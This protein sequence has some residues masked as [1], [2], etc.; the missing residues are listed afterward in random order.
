MYS[1]AENIGRGH[2]FLVNPD[3]G[4][5][6][7]QD[8]GHYP[9]PDI[10]SIAQIALLAQVSG[11]PIWAVNAFALGTFFTVAVAFY[12]AARIEGVSR[13][14]AVVLAVAFSV[15]PWHFVRATGHV[16]LA[17][18]MSVP[19]AIALISVVARR[20]L[21]R[22][23]S[24]GL[25]LLAGGAAVVV[26]A[27]GIYYALLTT[28]LL[29]A[30]LVLA[31]ARSG[32]PGWRTLGVAVLVPLSTAA[33]IAV[34]KA[35][36]STPSVGETVV[37]SPA[38]SYLYG[39]NIA[40]LFSPGRS[41]ATGEWLDGF[42]S[43]SFPNNGT[44]EGES[45]L[46]AAGVLAVLITCWMAAYRWTSGERLV[47]GSATARSSFWPGLFVLVVAFFA[48]GGFGALFLVLGECGHSRVGAF[49]HLRGGNRLPRLRVG[50]HGVGRQ[51]PSP[52]QDHRRGARR[53][54]GIAR[55][56]GRLLRPLRPEPG[57]VPRS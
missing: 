27:N 19:L 43:L 22:G 1:L 3:L 24:V 40:T 23:P 11:S 38:E 26:G 34:S 32:M 41:T 48:A 50:A 15:L 2:W 13:P 17:S 16:F 18:Y 53:G 49:L 44:F 9:I 42:L 54:H 20:R 57:A 7:F 29:V 55:R 35:S 21:D 4:Y 37:R 5:P 30:V 8:L 12:A 28:M 31:A 25:V 51:P 36:I 14:I 10:A 56:R 45:Y 52:C 46:S 47:R 6:G 39:G 33:S